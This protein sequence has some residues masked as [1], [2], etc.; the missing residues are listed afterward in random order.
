MYSEARLVIHFAGGGGSE[1][2]LWPEVAP[3]HVARVLDLTVEGFYNNCPFHRVVEGH[4]A[5]WGS[6]Q[7]DGL[8]GS[9]KG[10]L[11]AEFSD[12]PFERGVVGMAR[13]LDDPD[14]GDCQ[15]FVCLADRPQ[16]NGR[17]TALGRVIKER[18]MAS[19][20]ALPRVNVTQNPDDTM[21]MAGRIE[22]TDAFSVALP[23]PI[24]GQ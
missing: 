5:Q 2:Q 24:L 11:K 17:F 23:V 10:A 1:L 20:D 9:G 18:Y 12:V 16:L 7:E 15:L 21:E 14:S 19:F 8:G 13:D 3:N 4:V 6:K 22:R